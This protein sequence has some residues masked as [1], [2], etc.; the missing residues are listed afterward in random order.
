MT[1][2]RGPDWVIEHYEVVVPSLQLADGLLWR[3]KLGGKEIKMVPEGG[4]G[5][6]TVKLN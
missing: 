5:F 1:E 2:K 4:I 6:V 3:V